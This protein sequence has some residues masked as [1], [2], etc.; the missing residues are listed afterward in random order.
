MTAHYFIQKVVKSTGFLR[1]KAQ[2]GCA[3]GH[4]FRV[5]LVGLTFLGPDDASVNVGGKPQAVQTPLTGGL[6][7]AG[8]DGLGNALFLKLLTAFCHPGKGLNHLV[9]PFDIVV[10]VV[11]DHFLN[12]VRVRNARYHG[13]ALAQRQAKG[14][15]DGLLLHRLVQE[16]LQRL[17]E[18]GQN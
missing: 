7:L 8:D 2:K 18:G 3:A 9:V 6:E 10:P 14:V 12:P 11:L 1:S 16:M 5:G 13:Q 4:G 15:D 17:L